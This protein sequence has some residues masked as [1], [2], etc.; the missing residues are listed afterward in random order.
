MHLT[1]H[2]VSVRLI[3]VP[4][5]DD[6]PE[7]IAD[8]CWHAGATGI[9]EV[10]GALRV[11]VEDEDVDAFVAGLA[12]LGAVDVTEVDTFE[13]T[14]QSVTLEIVGQRIEAWVPPTVFGNGEHPTTSTCLRL[15]DGL[16]GP[17]DE[18]LDVGCG[19]GLL[20]IS[21]A[22]QGGA[23]TAIDIDPTAVEATLDNA[24]RNGLAVAASQ[25][26][27]AEVSSTF[28][29]VVANMTA[30]A[31]DPLLS[32]LTRCCRDGGALLV[33]GLLENQW[34]DVIADLGAR[35]EALE[36]VDTWLTALLRR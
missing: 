36:V 6:D 35:V 19:S 27:L 18:V 28:D 22:L 5:G 9:W 14:G 13:L 20:S 10:G 12:D 29:V 7:L 3:E 16:V 34:P 25:T 31:L 32:D 11:G 24:A 15:L 8:R 1:R 23:V 30:G 33:S 21:A 26:P 2:A 4:V 17:G